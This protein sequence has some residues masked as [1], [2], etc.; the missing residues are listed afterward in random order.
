[1]AVRL[2]DPGERRFTMKHG[3]M[4]GCVIALGLAGPRLAPAD[5]PKAAPEQQPKVAT[6]QVL[7]TQVVQ[8]GEKVHVTIENLGATD[9]EVVL[10]WDRKFGHPGLGRDAPPIT[11]TVKVKAKGKVV[12]WQNPGF[13][14]NHRLCDNP[15]TIDLQLTG[16]GAGV[17]QRVR[18]A[19]SPA[20]TFKMTSIRLGGVGVP[21]PPDTQVRITSATV[22]NAY[23]CGT[24]LRMRARIKNGTAKAAPNLSVMM[25][26]TEVGASPSVGGVGADLPPERFLELVAA[27][28]RI[29]T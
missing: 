26:E 13:S 17:D 27:L 5:T 16:S 29:R 22:E 25:L 3:W 24:K 18:H 6:Y 21:P 20:P 1:L 11:T 12:E 14:G 15:L 4:V 9:A 2:D 28:R 8:E 23:A 7:I 19:M 10:L